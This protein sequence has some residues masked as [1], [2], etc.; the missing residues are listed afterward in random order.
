MTRFF[1]G[2]SPAHCRRVSKMYVPKRTRQRG[3]GG[4]AP[5]VDEHRTEKIN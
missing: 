2:I 1:R 5:T 4:C 3:D